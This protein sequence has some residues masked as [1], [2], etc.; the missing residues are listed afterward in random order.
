MVGRQDDAGLET[1]S[2][3]QKIG[4]AMKSFTIKLSVGNYDIEFGTLIVN[5]RQK[6]TPKVHLSI[7]HEIILQGLGFGLWLAAWM[8]RVPKAYPQSELGYLER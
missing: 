8:I 7:K 1:H 5:M 6:V 3:T 2:S 4:A